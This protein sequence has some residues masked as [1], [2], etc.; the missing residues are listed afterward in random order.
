MPSRSTHV[1]SQIPAR[2]WG[3]ARHVGSARPGRTQSTRR[4]RGLF[5]SVHA[6]RMPARQGGIPTDR[7]SVLLRQCAQRDRRGCSPRLAS[8]EG[9]H[10]QPQPQKKV[11]RANRIEGSVL[12]YRGAA[13]GQLKVERAAHA[14]EPWW[15]VL[16][17]APLF[18]RTLLRLVFFCSHRH[19][20]P[21]MTLRESI[22]FNPRG[23]GSVCGR[24]VYV[25]CLDCGQ[26][27][28]YNPLTRRMIDFW[29]VHDAG[30]LAAVRQ[31]VDGFFSHVRNLAAWAGR[32][33]MRI[34][35]SE[36]VS[37]AHRLGILTK[38]R[39]TKS[40]RL[41]ASKWAARSDIRQTRTPPE[42]T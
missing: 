2:P 14:P 34:P 15:S 10:M 20:G 1:H 27:F 42:N 18:L 25:T 8:V 29:G 40:G 13:R 4:L 6:M 33:K 36:L 24:G 9:V 31:S 5:N 19:Q 41:L 28:A 26:K 11:A 17:R 7:Q 16:L 23:Y 12:L 3:D 21:P 30:A 38:S 35:M 22:P 37:S 32:L 39:W